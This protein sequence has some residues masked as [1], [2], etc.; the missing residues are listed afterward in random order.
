MKEVYEEKVPF[1]LAVVAAGIMAVFAVMMLALY[2]LQ[3]TGGPMGSRPA[4]DF[5]YLIMFLF[6][7]AVSA[8]I[9]SLRR[10]TVRV[11]HQAVTVRFGWIR[12]TIPW[13]NIEECFEDDS[14]LLAYAGWGIRLAPVKGQWRLAFNTGGK[15]AVVLRLRSGRPREFMFSTADAQHL[16]G[17]I[18][19]NIG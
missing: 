6:L 14:S 7:G 8:F 10:L 3:V 5:V 19:R 1:T 15:S 2:V 13:G 17:I 16:V 4:P 18:S 9:A 11:D 12:R